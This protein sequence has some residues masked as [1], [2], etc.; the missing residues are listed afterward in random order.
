MDFRRVF[1][2]PATLQD[3]KQIRGR[4]LLGS[5]EALHIINYPERYVERFMHTHRVAKR[6]V[7]RIRTACRY[8]RVIYKVS[9]VAIYASKKPS[10]PELFLPLSCCRCR[11]SVPQL[12]TEGHPVRAPTPVHVQLVQLH[13]IGWEDCMCD[14]FQLPRHVGSRTPSSEG[15]ISSES[16][17]FT[18]GT[19]SLVS[20]FFAHRSFRNTW[21]V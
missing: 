5:V 4:G 11:C 9:M 12:N 15:L 20:L 18:Y 14:R 8:H 10:D 7:T 16:Q 3:M 1:F 6:L 21:K 2:S 19:G 13:C 17:N